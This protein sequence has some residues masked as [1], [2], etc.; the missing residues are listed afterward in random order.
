MRTLVVP[1][2]ATGFRSYCKFV[3][4]NLWD[5]NIALS[6]FALGRCSKTLYV[7]SVE[8]FVS[9]KHVI[10]PLI[11]EQEV[12]SIVEFKAAFSQSMREFK[13]DIGT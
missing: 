5:L 10:Y 7:C 4:R 2:R 9:Y 8:I 6:C 13:K 11:T 3:N 12:E 1:H